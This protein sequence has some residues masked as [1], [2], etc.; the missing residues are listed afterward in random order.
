MPPGGA[1]TRAAQ[2]G[3]AR[4]DRPRARRRRPVR[5]ALRGARAVRGVASARLGR[6]LA[7]P[8]RAAR[9]EPRAPRARRARRRARQDRRRVVRGVGEGARGVGLR[10]V[11][12]VRSSASSTCAGSTSS[13]SRRTTTRTTCSSRTTSPGCARPRSARSSRCSAPE[14]RALVAEHATDEEDAFMSGPFP[15]AAQ[16]VLSR[17]LVEAFGATW[18]QFRLDTTVHPFEVTLRARRHP[19]DEPLRGGRP[20]SRSSPRCT[21]PGTAS[22]SGASARRSSA[23]RSCAGVVR[24]AARVAE[25]ALGERRRPLAPVLALVLPAPAGDVPRAS[26]ATCPLESFHRAVNRVRRSFIRVDAD[27]TS[28]GLHVIL[29]FELE[30]ELISGRLAVADLPDAWNTRFEELMGIPVPNDSLGVL[31]DAHWSG[32][33]FGYFPTY[34]LGTVLS[35]Q[36]WD[37]A[38]AAIPGRRRADRARRVRRAARV[39]ARE[40]LRARPQAH[41]GG[42]RR[43]R[44]RRPDRPAAVPRVSPRQARAARDARRA[45]ARE[46]RRPDARARAAL[47]ADAA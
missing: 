35:V 6:R 41:A 5:R 25:P 44:R 36:I 10:S 18:D 39:A 19:P 12:A 11:P 23:R 29:R 1:P 28:Y 40:H 34:L 14:L 30:Q 13:A 47:R 26:S 17:E 45:T 20:H 27:E 37:K 31:Q 43:A 2:L 24:D 3:D 15:I 42:D 22:T 9:L 33:G 7:H 32:G 16:E 21:R 46:A 38:R 4:G 8:C